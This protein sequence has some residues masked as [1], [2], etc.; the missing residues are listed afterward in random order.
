MIVLLLNADQ[1]RFFCLK[2]TLNLNKPLNSII[3]DQS[4]SKIQGS[5]TDDS[6]IHKGIYSNNVRDVLE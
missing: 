5:S 4:C 6:R 2:L 3:G 1:W